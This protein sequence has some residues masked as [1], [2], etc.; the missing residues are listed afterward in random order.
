M[1]LQGRVAGV[2]VQSNG[3]APGAGVSVV[4]RGAGTINGS[5]DPLYVVDGVFLESLSSVNPNDIESVEVLKDA[6]AA[7]IYGSRAANGVVIVTT[8]RGSDG[9]LVLSAHATV[10]IS[11][12]TNKI[13]FLNARQYADVRN[14][15]D[16]AGNSPRAPVNSTDFDPNVD[17]DWQDLSLRTGV[18]QDYGFSLAGGGNNSSVYF[19][20]NYF[21]ERGVLI[22]SDYNRI[23]EQKTPIVTIFGFNSEKSEPK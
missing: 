7:A 19:S 1:A 6:S 14:A 21:N 13:D 2:N 20:A 4:I 12:P 9:G 17:T 10:G 5:L 15:I 11:N 22:S 3:G 18:I 23:N 8:S 16:D